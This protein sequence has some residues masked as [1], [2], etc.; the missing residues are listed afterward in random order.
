MDG[1]ANKKREKDSMKKSLSLCTRFIAVIALVALQLTYGRAQPAAAAAGDIIADVDATPTATFGVS[2]AFDGQ[3]LYYTNFNDIVMHRIDVPPPGTSV[4]TGQMAFS[5]VGAPTG[6]NSFSW[7]ATRQMF[8]GVGGDGLSIYLLTKP[9]TLMPTSV[10]TLQFTID[11]VN[12]LPGNCDNASAFGTSICLALVDGLNY[13]GTDDTIWYSPDASQRVYHYETFA[14]GFGTAVLAA[15]APGYMD[16]N[17]PPNDMAPQCGTFYPGGPPFNYSSGVA[18]GGS[19][20]FLGADG[21][22]FYFRYSKTGTKLGFFP[23]TFERAEDMECDNISYSVSV[24]WA[25]D[26]Y[27]GHLRAFEQPQANAC[28]FGGGIILPAKA[29]MTGG[30]DAPTTVPTN[31]TAHHGFTLHC[32]ATVTPDRLEINWKDATGNTHRFHLLTE[33][34]AACS[35]DPLISPNPPNA[36][37]D[38]HSGKG[39]GRYDGTIGATVDWKFKDAGEPGTLDSEC[40]RVRDQSNAVV[41]YVGVGAPVDCSLPFSPTVLLTTG[42]QQAHD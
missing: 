25:R 36:S 29:R 10:A 31:S 18:V 20:L 11:P 38:T 6:I 28:I 12:D 42:N 26:A 35:D 2:V 32:D 34:D 33:T 30:G 27:D 19:D 40:I 4:A 1:W 7:D 23:Y 3:Y 8:W 17:D 9:T 37:F 21:C 39:T 14:D 13:D 41:L 5:I 24:I 22:A 15:P 16:V